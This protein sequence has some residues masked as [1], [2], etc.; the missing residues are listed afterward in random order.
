[1]PYGQEGGQNFPSPL[2]DKSLV[3]QMLT[4]RREFDRAK[5]LADEVSGALVSEQWHHTQAL[6]QSLMSLSRY[7][8]D[9]EGE[10]G[11]TLESS[12]NG[13][14]AVAVES[15]EPVRKFRLAGF[16]DGG[17]ALAVRNTSPRKIYAAVVARGI[18][19]AGEETPA[20]HGL[21]MTVDYRDDKGAPVDPARLL[22]GRQL[23][24]VVTVRNLVPRKIDNIALAFLAPAGWEI[25]NAPWA[26][27]GA[28]G[29]DYQDVR[30]DRVLS[31]FG[32]A[33]AGSIQIPLKF[34]AAYQGRFYLPA[35]VAEAM[36]E[37]TLNANSGGRWIAVEAGR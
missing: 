26:G 33:E 18:S 6:A 23:T 16:P 15:K 8:G 31:F 22:Q 27:A 2:R 19:A 32:L 13:A 12:V 9:Q 20:S 35:A 34:T 4:L 25:N 17:A 11:F 30:D 36:Y 1:V 28:T 24:A 14:A 21:E 29:L 10:R 3:L 7:Y 37:S 5:P